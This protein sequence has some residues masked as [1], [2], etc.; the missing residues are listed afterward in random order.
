MLLE[1][2]TDSCFPVSQRGSYELSPPDAARTLG[3]GPKGISVQTVS[4]LKC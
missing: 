4:K 2:A 1:S 3:N